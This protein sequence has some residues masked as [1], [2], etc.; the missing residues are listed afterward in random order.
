MFQNVSFTTLALV[1]TFQDCHGEVVTQN[2]RFG[3]FVSELLFLLALVSG[4]RFGISVSDL[5]FQCWS[6]GTV[7]SDLNCIPFV[8][9]FVDSDFVLHAFHF[10]TLASAFRFRNFR[11]RSVSECSFQNSP[12]KAFVSTGTGG[13]SQLLEEPAPETPPRLFYKQVAFLTGRGTGVGGERYGHKAKA[14][15]KV[16]E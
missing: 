12:F 15:F 3:T 13:T 7:A 2:L 8:S 1:L 16:L 9:V 5:P 11:H 10:I 6:F 4:L 14:T